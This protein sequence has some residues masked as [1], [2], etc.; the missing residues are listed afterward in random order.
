METNV[1]GILEALLFVADEPLTL[2]QFVQITGFDTEL[3]EK[4]LKELAEEYQ[5][6]NRGI[7]LR[8]VADGYR[9]FTHPAYAPFVEEL[10]LSADYRKLSQASLETLATIVYRQPITRARIGA[11]RG[12]NSTGAIASL[13]EKG[14]VKEVGR[15]RGP[16]QPILYGTTK[17]F[18]EN[19]GLK[20][21]K[22]LPPLKDFA[23][24]EET[25][26]QLQLRLMA[27]PVEKAKKESKE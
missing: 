16:G 22:E 12:V 5:K 25:I 19:F 21:I 10:V 18:L 2:K 13:Q 14:L 1:K 15:E 9:F 24:D 27:E 11:I 20:N 6:G 17:T 8:E 4:N 23:L 7:Q 26:D 3:I